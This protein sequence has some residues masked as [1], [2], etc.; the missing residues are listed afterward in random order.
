MNLKK[1]SRR[2]R[3]SISIQALDLAIS[4]FIHSLGYRSPTGWQG[5]WQ[6]SEDPLGSIHIHVC[7][8]WV[9][10]GAEQ[11][12]LGNPSSACIKWHMTHTAAKIPF[13]YSKKRNYGASVPISTFIICLWAIYIFPGSV[14][15]F[16]CSRIGRPMVKIY[17]SLT[18]TWVWKLGLRPRNSFSGNI[19]FKFS[20]LYIFAVQLLYV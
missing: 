12:T 7:K 5:P 10:S 11:A 6:L 2:C 16:S 8:A 14:H 19:C 13:M 3:A 15:I 4:R 20:V 9:F 18:D 1:K 17:K